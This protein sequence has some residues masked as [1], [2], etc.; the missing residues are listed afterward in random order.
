[1]RRL[2]LSIL[3]VVTVSV[4]A[5]A[6]DF[7]VVLGFRSNSAETNVAATSYDATT[8]FQAGVLG[9]WDY[10]DLLGLRGGFLYTQRNFNTSGAPSTEVKLGYF[11][12]PMTL[13]VKI[14]DYARFF[15]GPVLALNVSKKTSAGFVGKSPESASIGLQLG[16]SFKFAPQF[17]AELFYEM[18]PGRIWTDGLKDAKSVGANLLITFE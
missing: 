18:L 2:F 7:A 14:S 9:F 13:T 4:S 8:S 10:T 5:Q 1:M 12:V 11:D 6:N 16:A 15:A 17:G 3:A